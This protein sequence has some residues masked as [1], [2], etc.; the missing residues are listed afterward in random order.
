MEGSEMS[1]SSSPD[2][3]L[4]RS[5]RSRNKSSRLK[6]YYLYKTKQVKSQIGSDQA[7]YSKKPSS[8]EEAKEDHR[9][10]AAIDEEL[11]ALQKNKTWKIVYLPR[12]SP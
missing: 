1:Q 9:W 5:T 2:L 12:K 8:Y 10:S 7:M 11:H 3:Q 6:G 4:R